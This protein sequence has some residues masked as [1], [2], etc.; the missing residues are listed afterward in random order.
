MWYLCYFLHR[1]LDYR[2][3]EIEALAKLHGY[4][5][6]E[7]AGQGLQWKQAPDHHP[8]SPFYYVNL[9]NEDIARKIATQS[10]LL[11]GMYEVWGEGCTEEELKEAVSNYPEERKEPYLAE[12]STFKIVIDCF[13]KVLTFN[14][15]TA[16]IQ[17]V[18]YVP[19]KGQ[20]QLKKPQ[21]KFWLIDIDGQA[22]QNGLPPLAAKRLFFGR[23]IGSSD[24]SVIAKYELSRRKYLGPTAMDAEIALLMA[25]QALVKPGKLVYDP[26][27][28]TGSILVAAA[29]YGALTMGADIDIR[30]VRDGK[31]PNCNVWSNFKQYNLGEPLGLIRADNNSPPWRSDVCEMFDAIICDPPYGVRAGGRKSGGRKMLNGQRDA[32]VIPEEMKKDHIPSTAPYTLVECVHDLFDMAARL[33]VMGGRLVYFFPA[34]RED[35]SESHFPK[36]PCFTLIASSEQILSTRWSRCLITME[37]TAKYTEGLAKEAHQKHIDFKENHTQFLEENKERGSLHSLV[38]RPADALV[39]EAQR[40]LAAAVGT[41]HLPPEVRAKYRGKYV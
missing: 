15:Q 4:C 7:K 25:H 16:R 26:F 29:H 28:G 12:N 23:E 3:P 38:F 14:E 8:D 9:P 17:S 32:Y 22:Q 27:V 31:G 40:L 41:N 21:H 20:V 1:L 11:K 35:C 34:A 33:L 10:L 24:R 30:V 2:L 36:H 13:G 19:F 5:D 18:S 6:G 39:G 37:K